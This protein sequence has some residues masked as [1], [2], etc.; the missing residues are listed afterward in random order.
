RDRPI[1]ANAD[2]RRRAG[3]PGRAYR[4]PRQ[5]RTGDADVNRRP[6]GIGASA[7]LLFIACTSASAEDDPYGP[8]PPQIAPLRVSGAITSDATWAGTVYIT[9]GTLIAGATVT[10]SPGCTIEFLA[11]E[12]DANPILSV[13]AAG[14]CGHLILRGS[15]EQPIVF[16]TRD[17]TRPGS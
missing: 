17:G 7:L 6:M 2:R 5:A 12:N 10:V 3:L 8:A 9:G 1:R 16:R 15:E 4:I 14:K 11:A 13:G